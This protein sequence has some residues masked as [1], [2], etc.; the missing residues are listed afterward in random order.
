M[1]PFLHTDPARQFTSPQ[2][3]AKNRTKLGV[4]MTGYKY[5]IYLTVSTLL[6]F[7]AIEISS[8]FILR[9]RGIDAPM[10]LNLGRPGEDLQKDDGEGG[11]KYSTIDPHLGYIH[12]H[13]EKDVRNLSKEF[14]WLDGFLIYSNQ[15]SNF[16]RPIILALGGSTTDGIRAGHSWPEE[17]AKIMKEKR[18]SGTV[19]NGGI[20]GYS[21][22]QE[23]LKF[24]RDGLE[25]SPDVVISYSGINDRGQYSLLPFP[26]VHT[27]QRELLDAQTNAGPPPLL[28][29][30][31]LLLKQIT[32]IGNESSLSSTLGWKSARTL[33]GQYRKN[34]ELMNV[35]C[36]SRGC[37]FDAFIQPFAFYRSK[38]SSAYDRDRKG[39]QYIDSALSLYE[40]IIELPKTHAFIHDAT[41]ILENGDGLYM[42][43]GVHLN[44]EGDRI[45][46][47][48]IF[49]FLEPRLQNKS[50]P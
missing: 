31:I 46:G 13:G 20:G 36:V 38:H 29:S 4:T 15:T 47:A 26:M 39:A 34:M 10:F 49:Q 1:N 19:I 42:K 12:S 18:Y 40:E 28:P 43:D 37:T 5:G 32:G 50:S 25:L 41:Q 33:G 35:I 14:T 17:L 3:P 30:T 22:N 44:E 24:I 21:T 9:A 8:F 48:Y 23:L 45:V 11:L 27:Y 7:A 6:L 16:Q 2:E